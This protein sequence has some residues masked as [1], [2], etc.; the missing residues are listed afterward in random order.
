MAPAAVL[1]GL[2][3][4]VPRR[5][6]IY[7][8]TVYLHDKSFSFLLQLYRPDQFS[9]TVYRRVSRMIYERER[10]AV[11]RILTVDLL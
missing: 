3:R 8:H 10:T 2:A 7:I 1:Q 5:N 11:S 9:S 4:P 6:L